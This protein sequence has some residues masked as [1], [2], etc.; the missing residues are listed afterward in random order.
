[1]FDNE[2]LLSEYEKRL[3]DF[4]GRLSP[5]AQKLLVEYAQKL[6]PDE[7]ALRGETPEGEGQER[8]G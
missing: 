5:T 8:T 4:F 1:M 3:L 2:A 6:L 7:Q